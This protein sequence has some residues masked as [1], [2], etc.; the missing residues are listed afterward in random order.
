MDLAREEKTTARNDAGSLRG[1]GPQD[2]ELLEGPAVG[3]GG[4]WEPS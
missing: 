2:R 4:F 1:C 3:D